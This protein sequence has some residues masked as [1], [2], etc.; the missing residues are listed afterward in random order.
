MV[1]NRRA[2]GERHERAPVLSRDRP[3]ANPASG[4]LKFDPGGKRLFGIG[5]F[6]A[7]RLH[8]FGVSHN[9]RD[10]LVENVPHR[11]ASIFS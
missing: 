8:M 6:S 3:L 10:S 11:N 1:D 5:L 9:H 2:M 4:L 7:P